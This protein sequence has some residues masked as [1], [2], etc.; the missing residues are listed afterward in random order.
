VVV[1]LNLGIGGMLTTIVHLA[2]MGLNDLVGIWKLEN[3]EG[4]K[5]IN[6]SH[7]IKMW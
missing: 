4:K 5:H 1:I 7:Y 6:S 3:F 2:M